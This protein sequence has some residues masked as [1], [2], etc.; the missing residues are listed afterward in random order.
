MTYSLKL[1]KNASEAQKKMLLVLV[2][3]FYA[4][5][6]QPFDITASRKPGSHFVNM[7]MRDAEHF[8]IK[9]KT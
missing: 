8:C 5:Y 3:I 2:F 4:V 7:Q 9:E 6:S 1:D